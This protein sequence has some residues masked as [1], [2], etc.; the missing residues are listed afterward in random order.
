MKVARLRPAAALALLVAACAA[1]PEG[2]A[3]A[4]APPP[5]ALVQGAAAPAALRLLS[6]EPLGG[7]RPAAL[8]LTGANKPNGVEYRLRVSVPEETPAALPRTLDG[9]QLTVADPVPE[10]WLAFYRG[11]LTPGPRGE[12]ARFRARMLRPDGV[13]AWDLELNPHLSR[14]DR[15]EVQD[16]RYADGALYFNEACQSYSREAGGQ[17]SALVRLDPRTG[18]MAWRTP[19]LTSNGIFLLL[20]PYVVAGYGFTDEPDALFLVDRATGR[21]AARHALDSAASYMEVAGRRLVVLTQGSVY[22]F[23]LP[24]TAPRP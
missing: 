19:P 4:P 11:P 16:V 7:R 22:A 10:G 9:L 8:G 6:R 3:P 24:A 23:A 15:L 21:I 13:V 1:P 17:C 5:P 20:G 2:V 14:P 18:R 12:N